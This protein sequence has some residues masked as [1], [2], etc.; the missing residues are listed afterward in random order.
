[1]ST[2]EQ[3]GAPTTEGEGRVRG[4]GRVISSDPGT[5]AATGFYEVL[6]PTRRLRL[7]LSAIY[8]FVCIPFDPSDTI[9]FTTQI[10]EVI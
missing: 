1:M 5:E 8:Y 6:K 3:I 4:T 2:L 10:R 9:T 7:T